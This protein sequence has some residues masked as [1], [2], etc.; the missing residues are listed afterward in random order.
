MTLI[1]LKTLAPGQL[2]I[3][4]GTIFEILHLARPLYLYSVSGGMTSGVQLSG[5]GLQ[6]FHLIV[7]SLFK[8]YGIEGINKV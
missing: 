1:G 4:L 2:S 8:I 3:S 5:N 6:S 7:Q